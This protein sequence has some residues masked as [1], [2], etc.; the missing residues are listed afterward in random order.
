LDHEHMSRLTPSKLAELDQTS[1]SFR[2]LTGHLVR[3]HD[4]AA[5]LVHADPVPDDLEVAMARITS[6]I[7]DRLVPPFMEIDQE[8]GDGGVFSY[9]M[10]L[11]DIVAHHR[12]R[13]QMLVESINAMGVLLGKLGGLFAPAPTVKID[14]ERETYTTGV[15]QI[16]T[17]IHSQDKCEGFCVI[18]KPVPGPWKDWPTVWRGEDPFDIWRGFER[19]CPCGVGHTA[20]EETLRGN[21]HPHGCCGQCPCGEPFVRPVYGPGGE[22]EGFQ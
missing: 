11:I 5:E 13:D 6:E 20:M 12:R 14:I 2:E 3:L 10:F 15:G 19:R 18:H 9:V 17:N 16:L 7:F 1:A 22:L 21:S 8:D 4:E